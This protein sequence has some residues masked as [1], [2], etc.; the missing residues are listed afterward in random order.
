VLVGAQIF[1]ASGARDLIY[2]G[3]AADY[4]TSGPRKFQKY[5]VIYAVTELPRNIQTTL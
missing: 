2:N 4:G 3:Y 1:F 5:D